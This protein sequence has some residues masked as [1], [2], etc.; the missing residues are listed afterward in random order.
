MALGIGL[1]IAASVTPPTS[2][3]PLRQQRWNPRPRPRLEPPWRRPLRRLLT[4]G[5]RAS[6][7]LTSDVV[8][9][10]LNY[11]LWFVNHLQR[12]PILKIQQS[13]SSEFIPESVQCRP[14]LLPI[15]ACSWSCRRSRPSTFHPTPPPKVIIKINTVLLC[16]FVKT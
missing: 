4:E 7:P 2:F 13:S 9:R 16:Y 11:G 3:C 15:P 5:D 14:L 12:S 1:W 10:L 6:R 8:G